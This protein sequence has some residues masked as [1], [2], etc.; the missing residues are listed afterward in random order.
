MCDVAVC[1]CFDGAEQNY[2]FGCRFRQDGM[3]VIGAT[4][5]VKLLSKESLLDLMVII[6]LPMFPV[7]L[8]CFYSYIGMKDQEIAVNG[9]TTINVVMQEDNMLIDEVVVGYGVQ[10]KSDLTG[11]VGSI[12]SDDL[13]KISTPNVANA[14]QGRV[15]GVF[16]SASGAPGSSPEVRI[17]GIGTTNN[18][19]PLYVVDGMFM[20][21]ISFLSN[22]DIESMEVLK[23]AS[24]T[25]MYGSRGANGVIIVT[26]K[27]GAEGKAQVNITASEGFQFQNSGKFEMCTASEYAMLQNEANLNINPDGGL[28]YDDPA[29]FGKGTNWFDEIFRV[30]SVRDYQVA[31]SGGT[32]KV[33]YNLSAGYFQQD[34]IIK[35]NSYDRFTLRANNS[36]KINKHLTIGHNLSASF[37][38][39][40]MKIREL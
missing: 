32:E 28:V 29:S 3:T 27:Q 36:Y 19:N 35:E 10:R 31:V 15:S 11:A 17:R 24:A 22:H 1:R 8:S 37:S 38:H 4:V 2:G 30:A 21:D 6:R 18:S 34:G 7:T 25:A 33:R 39:T 5:S 13:K 20:D 9:R 40:K 23:D 26:T 14:L 16:I 12:K